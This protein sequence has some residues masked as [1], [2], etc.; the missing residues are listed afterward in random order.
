[1]QAP[2]IILPGIGGSGVEHWQSHWEEQD[3]SMRRFGPASWDQPDLDQWIVAL[4]EAVA[5]AGEPPLLVAH[6]LAC[7]LVAHWARR[8]AQKPLGAFLV[9]VPDADGKAFPPQAVS[10][11]DPPM[12]SLGFPAL[13]V[14][15]T[16]DPYGTLDHATSC[17]V[18]WDAGLVVAGALG[19]INGASRLGHWPQGMA[20]FSAFRAGAGG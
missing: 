12:R 6:S 4:D 20:L 18:A 9:S 5:E 16:D 3:P 19:H 15:S 10:F 13:I 1:M 11:R 2:V 8:S 14:A 7:L 17:A